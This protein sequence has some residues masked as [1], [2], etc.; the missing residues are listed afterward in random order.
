MS[1]SGERMQEGGAKRSGHHRWGLWMP[2]IARAKKELFAEQ[3]GD[4]FGSRKGD[5]KKRCVK[6]SK[7]GI[8]EMRS[9]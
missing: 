2:E 5:W 6:R 7:E 4:I 9:E 8:G 3:P 1:V